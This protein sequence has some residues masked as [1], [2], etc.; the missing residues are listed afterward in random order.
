MVNK[1]EKIFSK[2]PALTDQEFSYCPGCTHGIIHRLVAEVLEEL[3]VIDRTVAVAS[4]GCSVMSYNYFNCDTQQA[5]HGR[6]PAV[7]TGIKRTNPEAIVF[8]YQG[9]GDLGAIGIAE[10]IHAAG[11][12]E[13]IVIILVNNAIYG[14]TGGQMSPTSLIDQKTTTSQLGRAQQTQGLPLKLSEMFSTIPSAEL[15]ARSSVHNPVHIK[16]TKRLIKQAF[17]NQINNKGFSM[18]EILSTCSI[19][20]KMTPVESLNWL[21]ENMI[22]YYPLGVYRENGEINKELL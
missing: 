9:D 6:A 17:E 14:M 5:S 13:N 22:P 1:M 12:G 18:I 4:V 8:T 7:A 21:E 10:A 11:R 19:G 16:K 20:W 3:Q 2:T 15:I